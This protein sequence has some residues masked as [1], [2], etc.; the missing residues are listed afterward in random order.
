MFLHG[1]KKLFV[2][3]H[4]IRNFWKENFVKGF[5]LLERIFVKG[6]V[7]LKRIFVKGPVLLKKK[8]L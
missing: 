8:I 3:L 5:V 1:Y 7:L 2:K 4:I 6:F